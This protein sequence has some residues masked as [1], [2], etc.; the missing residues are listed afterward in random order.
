MVVF[1]LEK[2]VTGTILAVLQLDFV[3]FKYLHGA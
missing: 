2:E 3:V 1:Y